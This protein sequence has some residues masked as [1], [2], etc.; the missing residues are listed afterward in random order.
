MS[1]GFSL[2]LVESAIPWRLFQSTFQWPP[3]PRKTRMLEFR[4][5]TV[6][7][8]PAKGDTRI[9]ELAERQ[10]EPGIRID[11]HESDSQGT[12]ALWL[13]SVFQG[14]RPCDPFFTECPFTGT[15]YY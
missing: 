14:R 7:H 2:D 12:A 13:T 1:D 3:L 5:Q 11:G 6:L 9:T 4:S 8:P 15:T 10:G